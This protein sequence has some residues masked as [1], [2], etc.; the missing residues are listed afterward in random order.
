MAFFYLHGFASGPRSTKA[1]DLKRRFASLN[2]CLELPDLNQGNFTKLTLSRQIQQVKSR[3][4]ED[5]P[6]TII[7]S[8]FGGL[9]AAW[10]G[11]Q[12]K[13]VERLILLAPA[14]EF[15]SHW[16]PKIDPSD[17][18]KWRSGEPLFVHHYAEN[19][20]LPLDYGFVSDLEHYNEAQLKKPIPTLIL[21]GTQDDVIPIQASQSYAKI[22]PW[23]ELIELESDHALV[24]QGLQIWHAICQF[25][26]LNL[27]Q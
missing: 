17:L 5:E 7:G 9:T 20:S 24:D 18:Q 22:R 1:Q 23:V 27:E 26:G 16:L 11:Q 21:H 14:F 2:L 10:L 4:P 8:S 13:T 3:F 19:R 25:C 6:V 12:C 15:L